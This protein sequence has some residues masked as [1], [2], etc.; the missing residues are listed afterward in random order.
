MKR[1]IILANDNVNINLDAIVE[2]LNTNSSYLIFEKY[3]K[4]ITLRDSNITPDTF[5][6]VDFD[7]DDEASF[8]VLFTD[9]QY[10]NNYFFEG[11]NKTY[12]V[13][14]FA[15]EHL[16]TLS[17]N[18]GAAFFAIE[19]FALKIDSSF[20]HTLDDDGKPECIF[21]FRKDKTGIDSS[22]RSSAIC[23]PCNTRISEMLTSTD[24]K[25]A[26]EDVKSILNVI[27]NASKWDVDLIDHCNRTR[28]TISISNGRKNIFI[29]YNH[30][31]IEWL[32]R[33]KV[34]LKPLA[35]DST[36]NIWDDTRIKTG[37]KWEEEIE[38]A[39]YQSHAAILLVSANFLAS[40]FII[41]NELPP[42]LEKAKSDGTIICPVIL[43]PC[44]FIKMKQI[45]QFHAV[46]PPSRTLVEMSH[47]E[48]ERILLK[49]AQDVTSRLNNT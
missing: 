29:S 49:L 37:D 23:P 16:T 7:V 43:S 12:I 47:G 10:Y 45:S 41:N 35:P 24:K 19:I 13:S 8:C 44:S 39:L 34:H 26:F 14:F 32:T 48:Q 9:K 6:D 30:L 38:Q 5:N 3:K 11:Y 21:D 46:N 33:V 15:W 18:N 20:R 22:L 28:N 27:G 2:F 17:K 40:D 1:K 42:L 25:S 36:I 31:E 4:D